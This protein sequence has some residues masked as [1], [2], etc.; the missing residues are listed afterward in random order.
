MIAMRL[1]TDPVSWGMRSLC[2]AGQLL[3]GT[4]ANTNVWSELCCR[5]HPVVATRK[6]TYGENPYIDSTR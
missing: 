6:S 3:P 5:Y 2:S 4:L 1:V